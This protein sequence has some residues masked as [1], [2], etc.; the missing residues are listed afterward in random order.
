M[1]SASAERSEDHAILYVMKLQLITKS[2]SD[3]FDRSKNN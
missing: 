2:E 1:M 3:M